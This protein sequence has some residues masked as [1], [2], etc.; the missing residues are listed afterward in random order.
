MTETAAFMPFEDNANYDSVTDGVDPLASTTSLNR[1]SSRPSIARQFSS[2]Y[3]SY[4]NQ[5]GSFSVSNPQAQVPMVN[6]IHRMSIFEDPELDRSKLY[7]RVDSLRTMR[8]DKL[9]GQAQRLTDWSKYMTSE[10]KLKSCKKG[11]REF[12]SDQN[13]LIDRYEDVDRLLDTD[14]RQDMIRNYQENASAEGTNDGSDDQTTTRQPLGNTAVPGNIDSEGQKALGGE[15]SSDSTVK[16][17]IYI[18]FAINVVLLA[19]KVVVAYSSK[20]MSIIAS[21]VDSVLDL[22]STLIIFFANKYA[23]RTSSKFPV[24]RKRLE[25]LGVLVFSI[26]IIISFLQ[27]FISS[28]ERLISPDHSIVHLSNSSILIMVITISL[29]L[30]CYIGCK[31]IHNS[32]VEALAEDAKTDVIFNT[33]S[34]IFPLIEV[35]FQIWWVDAAGACGLCLYVISQW[36]SIMLEHIDH[37]SG[38]HASKEDY[39]E[40]LYMIAR[41]SQRIVAI[42]NYLIYHQGDNLNVEVDVVVD[43]SL[44]LRNAHDLGESLQ[45]A[46]ETLPFVE[47]CFV[48]LDYR[49][50]NYVGHLKK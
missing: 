49:V 48:H 30:C 20:S 35:E 7:G 5:P 17:A 2:R 24:G 28:A 32:S 22:M 43:E 13:E 15:A 10:V 39:S 9:I 16:T 11:A 21:L 47:R 14:V 42:K 34:L 23:A 25:P 3:D 36:A 31:Q 1:Y 41:Y 29:K 8:P 40:I 19:A 4:T 38:S 44:D 33:F 12:Y 46:I 26:V 6:A 50:D 37:L 45:Y 27:V 18:N